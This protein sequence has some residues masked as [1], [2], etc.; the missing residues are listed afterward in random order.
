MLYCKKY[1]SAKVTHKL[2]QLTKAAK[3]KLFQFQ[4]PCL[5]LSAQL[6]GRQLMQDQRRS[7]CQ[8]ASYRGGLQ[9]HR[10]ARGGITGQ[11]SL[12]SA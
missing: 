9:T 10:G 8:K 1:L 5:D 11:K 7:D 4:Q 12:C 3:T 2:D 6:M